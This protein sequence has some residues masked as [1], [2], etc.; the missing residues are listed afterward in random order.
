MKNLGLFSC[1]AMNKLLDEY[2]IKECVDGSLVDDFLL[3]N[4]EN[5]LYYACFEYYLNHWSSCYNVYVGK[6]NEIYD[7]WY[8]TLEGII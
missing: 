6:C 3:Y 4:W 2:E 1:E 5:G 8:E 7:L